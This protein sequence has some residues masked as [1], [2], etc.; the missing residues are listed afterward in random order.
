VL[1]NEIEAVVNFLG[2]NMTE[3]QAIQLCDEVRG[4]GLNDKYVIEDV[5]LGT[6]L[7]TYIRE[8]LSELGY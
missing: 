7:Y 5:S 4:L 8:H 2:N 1:V 3:E 6:P